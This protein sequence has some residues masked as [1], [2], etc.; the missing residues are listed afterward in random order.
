MKAEPRIA[1]AAEK[2]RA[3][4]QGLQSRL[5]PETKAEESNEDLERQLQQYFQTEG[6]KDEGSTLNEIRNRVVEGVVERILREW[7]RPQQGGP[8]PLETEVVTR[9]IDRVL[10]RLAG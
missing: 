4:I 3:L 2:A 1:E 6:R 10:E 9:L 8:T 7:D 5:R